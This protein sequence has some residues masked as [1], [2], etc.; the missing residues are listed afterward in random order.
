MALWPRPSEGGPQGAMVSMDKAAREGAWARG[1][2]LD[3]RAHPRVAVAFPI[4]LQLGEDK[5][6]GVT[7]DLGLGGMR[8]QVAH[9]LALDLR[10]WVSMELPIADRERVVRTETVVTEARVVRAI[11]IAS[12]QPLP[13]WDLGLVFEGP[14]EARD[15]VLGTFLLQTLLFD[16]GAELV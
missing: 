1:R 16:P 8:A 14:R 11:P 12:R 7:L 2:S 10:V 6:H 13:E 4:G 15:R 9:G 5:V 3:R